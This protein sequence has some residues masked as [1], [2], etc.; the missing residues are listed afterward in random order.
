[1]AYLFR[2]QLNR[3][4]EART[5]GSGALAHDIEAHYSEDGVDM[6]VIGGRH[7]TI[8][9]L[10]DEMQAILAMPDVTGPQRQAK[11]AAYK[12]ALVANLNTQPVGVTG[13]SDA[14]MAVYLDGNKL[15]VEVA[16]G[17]N[18]YLTATL[19][20]SYPIPFDI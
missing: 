18:D 15:S 17:A 5:D 11:N 9:V 7:K 3:K 4:P 8:V 16:T 2:Y 12:N 1:M 10:G 6:G 19:G 20:L 13:W 14:Q